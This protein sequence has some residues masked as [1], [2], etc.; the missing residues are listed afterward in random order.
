VAFL[1]DTHAL[2]WWWDEDAK[3]PNRIRELMSDPAQQLWVSAAVG[4]EIAIKV[5]TGKLPTMA[6]AVTGANF[7]QWVID[8]GFQLLDIRHDHGVMAGLLPGEHRD[9]FDR[10]IAAQARIEDLIVIT[11]DPALATFGCKVIW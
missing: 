6:E 7:G 5:R 11:R 3:L 1:L 10:V 2:I 9:P 8:D 4:W